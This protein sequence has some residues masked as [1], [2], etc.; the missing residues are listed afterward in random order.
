MTRGVLLYNGLVC[1][2]KRLG[3]IPDLSKRKLQFEF[4]VAQMCNPA[5][6]PEVRDY[7]RDLAF[8]TSKI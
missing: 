2:P 1:R 6:S 8:R 5:N 7:F 3:A 4:F